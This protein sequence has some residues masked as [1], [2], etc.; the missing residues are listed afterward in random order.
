MKDNCSVC[1][2]KEFC[3][4]EEEAPKDKTCELFR[5]E[6]KFLDEEL[7]GWA[8]GL[9]KQLYQEMVKEVTKMG[10]D[11]L[12]VGLSF[13]LDELVVEET[14][15]KKEEEK[16]KK[17]EEVKE[18]APEEVIKEV[19][20]AEEEIEAR[21]KEDVE[22]ISKKIEEEKEEI[23][24]LAEFE[25]LADEVSGEVKDKERAQRYTENKCSCA[26]KSTTMEDVDLVVA[27][28]KLINVL[29]IM[30][31]NLIELGIPRK[32][33]LEFIRRMAHISLDMIF[34]AKEGT[35]DEEA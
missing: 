5:P 32:R 24:K 20:K 1:L 7:M 31:A 14:P 21:I 19:V 11:V 34:D 26:C 9:A 12:D 28:H 22:E 3:Y 10:N 8:D 4:G 33:A 17:E 23:Q 27:M 13:S 29:D 18:V 15:K 30:R 6:E 25:K 16:P 35:K 2:G